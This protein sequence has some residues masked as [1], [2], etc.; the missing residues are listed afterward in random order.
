[1][2]LEANVKNGTLI[3]MTSTKPAITVV[4]NLDYLNAS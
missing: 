4:A 3:M 1:M 2:W